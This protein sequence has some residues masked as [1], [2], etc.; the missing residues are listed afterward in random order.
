[1]MPLLRRTPP[2]RVAADDVAAQKLVVR[3]PAEA[4]YE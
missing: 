4:M 2:V 3:S 1:M